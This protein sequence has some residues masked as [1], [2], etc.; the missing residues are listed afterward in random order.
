MIFVV[1]VLEVSHRG[2]DFVIFS[3]LANVSPTLRGLITAFVN[4]YVSTMPNGRWQSGFNITEEI[5]QNRWNL[6][7]AFHV[8]M[9]CV[10]I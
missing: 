4:K 3:F 5:A 8:Q 6:F 10:V 7:V 1:L 2:A 9:L